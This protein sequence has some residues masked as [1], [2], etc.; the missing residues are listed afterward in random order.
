MKK[1][2]ALPLF[3]LSLVFAGCTTRPVEAR[4]TNPGQP[5]PAVG[6][7]VGTVAGAVT[8]QVVG[9]VAGG[10]EGA[11]DAV[12]APFN[13]ERRYVRRWRTE[14]TSDGRTIQVAEEIEV[15][16]QGRPIEKKSQ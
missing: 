14:T 6:H 10:V 12:K 3:A 7:A 8:G 15:D 2:A 4:G 1:T 9:V 5:G 11:S 16:A 13:N